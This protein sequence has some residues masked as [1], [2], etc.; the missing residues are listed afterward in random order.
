M[1]GYKMKKKLYD[2][3]SPFQKIEV[4]RTESHG[5]MML[6][7]ECFMLNEYE[8]FSYHEMIA[9]V[10]LYSHPKPEKVLVVGGGDGGT[11]RETLKHKTVREVDFV[12][13]DRQV[14]EVSRKY[15][16]KLTSWHGDRRVN[17]R[18]EDASAFVKKKKNYYDVIIIDSTDPVDIGEVLYTAAFYGDIKKALKKN[19]I[20]TAQTEDPYYSGDI[21]KAVN[22]KMK[23][24]FS[25]KN[26]ALYTAFVPTY[27]SGCWTFGIAG[28]SF[29]PGKIRNSRPLP[30]GLKY[31]SKKVHEASFCLPGFIGNLIK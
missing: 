25:P 4:Y 9:H 17:F 23:K 7:D 28:R 15:F 5:N 22:K 1:L 19:G 29:K 3:R 12:E 2:K 30:G 18:F 6:L 14:Y 26:T 8:E 10:P 27:P 11:V 20:V 24:S 21:L 13:I 31:Y 16:K